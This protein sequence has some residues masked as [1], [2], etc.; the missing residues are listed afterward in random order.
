MSATAKMLS[1]RLNIQVFVD[2]RIE[3]P[4]LYHGTERGTERVEN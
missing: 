4:S 1:A 2:R 3:T